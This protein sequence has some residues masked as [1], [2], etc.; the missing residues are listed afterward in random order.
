MNITKE[1]K[2]IKDPDVKRLFSAAINSKDFFE[3]R[4]NKSEF[5]AFV[6]IIVKG[7]PEVSD[8]ELIINLINGRPGAPVKT[9]SKE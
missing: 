6:G 7:A 8:K 2:K 9:K 5:N 1:L 4:L 3:K